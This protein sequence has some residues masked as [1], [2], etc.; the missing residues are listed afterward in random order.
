VALHIDMHVHKTLSHKKIC[1]F[2]YWTWLYFIAYWL[3]VVNQ[4]QTEE[5]TTCSVMFCL[6]NKDITHVTIIFSPDL[7]Q[8]LSWNPEIYQTNY[9][10][11]RYD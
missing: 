8:W 3:R 4:P 6:Y 11:C 7:V 1:T 9:Q 5:I 10:E 2:V